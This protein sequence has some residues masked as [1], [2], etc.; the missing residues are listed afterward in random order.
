MKTCDDCDRGFFETIDPDNM[1]CSSCMQSAWESDK[2][3]FISNEDKEDFLK[4]LKEY[5]N[6]FEQYSPEV[7][8]VQQT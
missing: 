3:M 7:L 1:L 4:V 2:E 6:E 8:D 5:E